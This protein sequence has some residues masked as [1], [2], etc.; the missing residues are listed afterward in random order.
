MEIFKSLWE[1]VVDDDVA[2]DMVCAFPV[3]CV[4]GVFEGSHGKVVVVD[5][6]VCAAR[7]ARCNGGLFCAAIVRA[8][9]RACACICFV[10]QTRFAEA[11]RKCHDRKLRWSC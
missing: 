4:A 10:R 8:C 5:E 7:F 6:P 9:V 3:A 2:I 11:V 1:H